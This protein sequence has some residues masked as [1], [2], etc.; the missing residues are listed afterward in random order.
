MLEQAL[1]ELDR[2][3]SSFKQ[4]TD[5]DSPDWRA[6]THTP[7]NEN[8]SPIRCHLTYNR[9]VDESLRLRFIEKERSGSA[10]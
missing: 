2:Q 10:G 8:L 3:L 7:Y 5:S 1:A 9:G 4:V 6:R